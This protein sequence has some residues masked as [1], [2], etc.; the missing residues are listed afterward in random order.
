MPANA[1]NYILGVGHRNHLSVR[2]PNGPG[3]AMDELAHDISAHE[4]EPKLLIFEGPV[5]LYTMLD[6]YPPS[7]LFYPLHLYFPPENDTSYLDTTDEVRKILAWKPDVVVMFHGEGSPDENQETAPLV[8]AYARDN[9]RLWF[10]RDVIEM[11]GPR[12]ID[13]YGDCIR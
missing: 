4:P 2:S 9:C 10:T 5:Y 11:F 6:S 12:S 3:I 13:V 1:G 7:P 8:R